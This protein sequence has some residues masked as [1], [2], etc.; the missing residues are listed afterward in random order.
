MWCPQL[1]GEGRDCERGLS[2]GFLLASFSINMSASPCI[3]AVML[4]ESQFF[5]S[6]DFVSSKS[7]LAKYK[8]LW[9]L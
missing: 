5:D 8:Y 3:G 4:A 9:E 2:Q 6:E 7:F 1:D